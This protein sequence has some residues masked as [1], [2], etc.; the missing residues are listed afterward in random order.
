MTEASSE[1]RANLSQILRGV[2]G[3]A[4]PYLLS[5]IPADIHIVAPLVTGGTLLYIAARLASLLEPETL[6]R[7]G[8]LGA[9]IG[10]ALLVSLALTMSLVLLAEGGFAEI[11]IGMGVV[12]VIVYLL[13]HAIALPWLTASRVARV[14]DAPARPGLRRFIYTGAF[15]A[16]E[17]L[18]LMCIGLAVQTH[19]EARQGPWGPWDLVPIMPLVML[20][21]FY[22]PVLRL[23]S[24]AHPR[25]TPQQSEQ[26]AKEGALLQ[27]GAVIVAALTGTI[28]LL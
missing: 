24:A 16:E 15:V 2:L 19:V 22:L 7:G 5:A 17:A 23:E 20:V 10:E 9:H 13:L 14:G 26:A 6:R 27:A 3:L 25:L 4:F 18:A 21:F 1:R 8:G 11:S 12:I 28:P